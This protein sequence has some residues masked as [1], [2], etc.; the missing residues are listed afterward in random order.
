[1]SKFD[2]Y[3]VLLQYHHWRAGEMYV[4]FPRLGF[5]ILFKKNIFLTICAILALH[6]FCKNLPLCPIPHIRV[7]AKIQK[8]LSYIFISFVKG[9]SQPC[10]PFSKTLEERFV[11]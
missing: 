9:A 6:T 11:L 4:Q 1:M 10:Q 8:L 2:H 5:F 7:Q 3:Q